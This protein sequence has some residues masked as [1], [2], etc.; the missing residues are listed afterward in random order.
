MRE[1]HQQRIDVSAVL[2]QRQEHDPIQDVGRIVR[3]RSAATDGLPRRENPRDMDLGQRQQR[4]RK[5]LL[6]TVRVEIRLG[7]TGRSSM[8]GVDRHDQAAGPVVPEVLRVE[9]GAAGEPVRR[10]PLPNGMDAQNGPA[11]FGMIRHDV[12]WPDR[13]APQI[14][15]EV[16]IAG[17]GIAASLVKCDGALSNDRLKTSEHRSRPDRAACSRAARAVAERGPPPLREEDRRPHQA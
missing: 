17:R 16:L 4:A 8:I 1:S 15:T 2:R 12:L 3:C 7:K 10:E 14:D 9:S 5:P 11:L 6:R 13:I